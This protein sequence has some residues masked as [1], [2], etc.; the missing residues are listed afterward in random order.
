MP[1]K[2]VPVR[3]LI[4][5]PAVITLAV[6]LL[7]LV[8]EL[9]GW[10]PALFNRQAGGGFALVGIVWLVF[11]FGAWFAWKLLDAGHF[12]DS[13]WR[14]LLYGFLGL[15][16]SVVAIMAAQPLKL[17]FQATLLIFSVVSIVSLFIAWKG[18]PAL[19]RTLVVYGLAARIPVAIVMLVAM[20]GNWG[21]HYDVS[22][23]PPT[24]GSPAFPE[25]GPVQKWF[26]I[27]LIPQLTGW[28]GFTVVFGM[29]FGGF[30]AAAR[31][32]KRPVTV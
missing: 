3:Q 22:P 31:A 26:W 11:V 28:M 20:L 17:P 4:L 23:P 12:P 16:L 15:V 13:A 7:R 27:G 19:G 24:D 2:A 1:E 10:S 29:I 18:W 9:Q 6:T 5:V 30:V 32:R 14:P 21:T 8:G 25:M